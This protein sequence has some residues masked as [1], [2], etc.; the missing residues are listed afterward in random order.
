MGV[1][2]T[3]HLNRAERGPVRNDVRARDMLDSRTLKPVAGPVRVVGD[4]VLRV[5]QGGDAGLGKCVILGT[6][7]R[8]YIEVLAV[9]SLPADFRAAAFWMKRRHDAENRR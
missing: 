7:N 9:S 2:A 6:E 5:E 3:G 8:P 4:R 1:S